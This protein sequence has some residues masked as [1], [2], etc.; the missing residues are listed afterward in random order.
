MRD[1][2]WLKHEQIFLL[3]Y[4]LSKGLWVVT[5]RGHIPGTAD[6]A[7]PLLPLDPAL[8]RGCTCADPSLKIAGPGAFFLN[9]WGFFSVLSSGMST[10][11]S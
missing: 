4:L 1:A 11:I 2:F 5:E 6:R 8:P 10:V 7:P 3:S 9:F